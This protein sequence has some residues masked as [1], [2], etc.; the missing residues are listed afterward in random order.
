MKILVVEDDLAVAQTLEILFASYSYAVDMAADGEAGLQMAE[1]FAYDLVLLDVLLPKLNGINVCQSLRAKG[2]QKP[3]LLLTGQGEE[4]KKAIAL[5]AGADDY[6]VKPFN[7]E[8]LIARVQALLRRSSSSSQPIL[9][10][11]RLTIDPS[12]RKVAYDTQLLST[13]PKEYAILELFLR[14]PHKPFS[15]KAILDNVWTSLESPGEEAIRVH[16]KELRKKLTAIDA[17]KDLIKTKHGEGYQLNP[18]YASTPAPQAVSQLTPPQI[19]ELHAVNE[20]LRETLEKLRTVQAELNLKHEELEIAYQTIEQER[21][22]LKISNDE[23]EQRVTERTTE[24][25]QREKFLSSIY[26]GA[27][28]AIFV[29]D[30]NAE[31][32]L[33]Y[34]GYNRLAEQYSGFSFKDVYGKTPEEAFGEEIG[35]SFRHNYERCLEVKTSIVYEEHLVFGER[36]LWTLTT[37]SPIHNDQGKIYRIVGTCVNITERKQLELDLQS[38]EERYRLMFENNPNPMWFYDSE[39]LA[40]LEVN[41]AA[42]AHYGYSK[43]EF[44]QM[45][46]ADIRPLA[47][48][49]LVHQV[50]KQLHLGESHIGIWQHCKKDNSIIDVEVTAFTFPVKGKQANLVIIKD[51]TDRKQL[52]VERHQ[53]KVTI[54][55]SEEQ[56]RLALELT[57]LG[58]W[59][60]DLLTGAVTWTTDTQYYLFGYQPGTIAVDYQKWRDRVHSDD[61]DRVEETVNAAL[62]EQR[63]INVEYRVVLPDHSHR[64]ILTKGRGV[65][66]E[67]GQAIRVVGF[68]FDIS[69]RK[70][71]EHQ[72]RHVAEIDAFRVTLSDTLRSLGQVDEIMATATQLLGEHLQ[73]DRA[74]YAEVETNDEY[75]TV[76]ASYFN[77]GKVPSVSGRYQIQD[78][79]TFTLREHQTRRT[80]VIAD[81]QTLQ[82]DSGTEHALY[83][84]LAVR[85]LLA[86][87]LIK[88]KR[89]V[90]VLCVTCSTPRLWT[91]TE[92][93]LVEKTAERTWAALKR[94]RTDT[95][96]HKNEEMLRFALAGSQAG[97][98]NWDLV[99]D[100]LSW[101]PETYKLYGLN[102]ASGTPQSDVWYNVILH[103]DDR[104][105]M[106]AYL[107]YALE[108]RLPDFQIEFRIL[109]PQLGVRWILGQGQL[110]TSEQGEPIRLS[111]INLD[112]SDRKH[113]ELSLQA[114]EAKLNGILN[115]AIAAIS[116]FRVYANKDWEYEYWSAGCETLFGYSLE[117]LSDKYFWLS[118]VLPED[119]DQQLMPLFDAF[120]AETQVTTEYRFRRKDGSVRWFSSSYS[121]QKIADDCWIVTTVNHDVSDRKQAEFALQQQ[122]ER[123]LLITDIAQDIRRSLNLNNVLSRTVQR[124]REF[125]KTDRT[126]IFRFRADWQGDV[127]MES[128]GDGWQSILSTTIF[129]PCFKD[130]CVEPYAQG[131][132][133]ALEDVTQAEIAPCYIELLQQFQVKANLVVPILQGDKLWGLLI[134]HQCSSSRQWEA[135]EIDLLRQLATQV[136]IAIQQSELYEQTR[137]ELVARKQIQTV[138][139]ESEERFRT[140]SA[141]APVGI[142]QANADGICLYSNTQWQEISGLSFIDSLGDGWLQ[143]VHPDDWQRVHQAWEAYV[144]SE[145]G[146][147][148]EFR[149][150][151]P[152]GDIRWVFMRVSAIRSTLE[153][154]VGF[155]STF[156]DITDRK[157]AEIQLRKMSTALS[158][159]V[160]GISQLDEQGRYLSVN[161]AYAYM[162][163]Y[164]PDE[165][166][167]MDWQQTVHPHDL[168]KVIAAYQHML[169]HGKVEVEARGIRKDGS[170]FYKEVSMIAAYNDQHELAGHYCFTK[171]ISEKKRLEAD[172][173]QA[174]QAL[175]E[176]ERRLQTILDNSPAAIYLLDAQHT[177]LFANQGC[178]KVLSKT[179]EQLIGKSI[180]EFW[181]KDIADSFAE[182]SRNVYET[183]QL[184][185]IEE[186]VPSAEG[187]QIYLT[188]KFRLCDAVGNP[189]AVC[190]ISTDITEKKQLEAQFYRAQRLESLGTL[191]SG[192]AHDLNNVLTPIVAIAQLLRLKQARL[193]QRSQE[194]VKVIEDS[195]KR[196]ANLIK[197][198]LTFARGTSGE[199]QPVMIVS[200]L[201]EVINVVQ[202]TFPKSITIHQ[203]LP[204]DTSLFVSADSTCLHQVFMNLCVNA[205][206]AMPN[207]GSLSLSIEPCF[208]DQ[209]FA[210]ANLDAQVGHYVVV[211]I[212]DTGVG[213]PFNVR[214]HIFEPFFTT[215]K[216]G[217]GT[218]LGLA[219]ALGIVRDYGGFLQ[220]ESEVGQ[221]TEMKVYLP[222]IIG[223]EAEAKRSQTAFNGDGKLVLIVD[224]DPAVQCSTQVLLEN[225]HYSVLVAN[226]GIAAIAL[227]T[228]RQADIQLVVLDIMMPTVDGAAV[229]AKLKQ[230]NPKVKI[231]AMSGL[232]TNREA[233][234]AAGAD[235]FL[236]KPYTLDHLLQSIYTLLIS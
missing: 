52:E 38:S 93:A 188:V 57:R 90:A 99:T 45:T 59:D 194:M 73:V 233:A 65:Y 162:T 47:D 76:P 75:I 87:P 141:A 48:R 232:P 145:S 198:I 202:Q 130:Q 181:S 54:Q 166:I 167:R 140:L 40:F 22:R 180:Y 226:D 50:N 8:E 152:E 234:L 164:T 12:R 88:A 196:G 84:A 128:V 163:G 13:T 11:G 170:V 46:I 216:I 110:A 127:I 207:G 35:A 96:L 139:E 124:V 148:P 83:E 213:I 199:C 116:S 119:R 129:D 175:R 118:Q 108:Q 192:I 154:I 220:V 27:D 142:L 62:K 219:T 171:D 172:R 95:V 30:L 14:N 115:S 9:Q 106:Q 218:G 43:D 228:E 159:S 137:L 185:Q 201:Q 17:P 36:H 191:A 221:G 28:Q 32:D 203:Y 179:P 74:F 97:T 25:Q 230:I 19:A 64:W 77:N 125:L 109:H 182:T 120:F 225:H 151:T 200:L 217:Q 39:T 29:V 23:L 165:M 78:F 2:F 53:A 169:K 91:E 211:T 204:D 94:T 21:Q 190:S 156:E 101:S 100:S 184:L 136:G 63:D 49:C 33:Y 98:W 86:Y 205:R 158:H 153:E 214:D 105:R 61:I 102:P 212:T 209:V 111:G 147:V 229:I 176:S 85:A 24:L 80:V 160:E 183:G 195:A 18:L 135:T 7:A 126:L 3:I 41:Q 107:S 235:T 103:P 117:E 67:T 208:I 70:Q 174:E 20:E 197:Q 113:L 131:K 89:L 58:G 55:K 34:S 81:V 6:V 15:A 68:N 66:S 123:E 82:S 222:L 79:S 161:E 26:H 51:I 31:N 187:E 56:L 215:K 143:A 227:Y 104:E 155:V 122:I 236:S 69:D 112:I 146:L 149:L 206:D 37:L 224:D 168:E 223:T 138:L 134:A 44:L 150:L 231:I 114:S 121:S 186:S 132:I 60:W 72:L 71:A 92:I 10:W 193:D 1:A 133:S 4:R 42:I 16:I 173:R 178:A 157:Q 210:Q 177:F 144:H 5:N 189:Y